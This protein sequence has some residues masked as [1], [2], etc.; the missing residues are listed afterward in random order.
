MD[1][2]KMK[3]SDQSATQI[4]RSQSLLIEFGAT[5][6]TITLSMFGSQANQLLTPL[7]RQTTW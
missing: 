1:D 7:Q 4:L 5:D 3:V 6:A 2:L